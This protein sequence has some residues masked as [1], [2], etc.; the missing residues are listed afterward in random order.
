MAES[1]RLQR[2]QEPLW[3]LSV[4]SMEGG[5]LTERLPIAGRPRWGRFE[6]S[7]IGVE[8]DGD[9]L[10]RYDAAYRKCAELPTYSGKAAVR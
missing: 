6:K 8:I 2:D 9:K 5:I 1:R 3:R 4:Q 7:W 10:H